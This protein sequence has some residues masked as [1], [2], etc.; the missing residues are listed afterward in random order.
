[1]KLSLA[2]NSTRRSKS[3]LVIIRVS[4]V[5]ALMTALLIAI[6][7]GS[8]A[9]SKKAGASM[10]APGSNTS[11]QASPAGMQ[12]QSNHG[13]CAGSQSDGLSQTDWGDS[14]S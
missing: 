4:L 5:G 13:L 9:V 2:F 1:M 12:S 7:I 14:V 8:H 11:Y 6:S 10:N 3:R